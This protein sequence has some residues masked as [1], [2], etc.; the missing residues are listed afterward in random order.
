[1]ITQ[2]QLALEDFIENWQNIF[3]NDNPQFLSLLENLVDFTE[4][5]C[6]LLILRKQI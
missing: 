3:N 1:M 4:P 5:I 2:K 6:N